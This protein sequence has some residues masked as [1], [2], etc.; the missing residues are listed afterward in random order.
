MKTPTPK[1][2]AAGKSPI[3][4][5]IAFIA[6]ET[7]VWI[8]IGS[9]KTYLS[10]KASF[11]V[12]ILSYIA[13]NFGNLIVAAATT[14]YVIFTYYLLES[15]ETSRRHSVE[16]LLKVRWY[17][18]ERPVERRLVKSGDLSESVGKWFGEIGVPI[19]LGA[20]PPSKQ[21]YVIVEFS[22]ARNVLIGEIQMGFQA[23]L[24]IPGGPSQMAMRDNI[25]LKD[26]NLAQTSNP[27]AVTVLD[28]GCIPKTASVNAS[29]D[30]LIYGSIEDIA[31]ERCVGEKSYVTTGF[32][33]LMTAPVPALTPTAT[34]EGQ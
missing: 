31:F 19:D 15:T 3:R 20:L 18:A 8:L 22:N 26:L 34:P 32:W 13:D 30:N 27:I 9:A 25:N 12:E 4:L 23:G 11:N 7:M 14:A 6:I 29:L 10:G 1:D 21:R 5:S 33:E 17:L 2:T 16:P 28:L 24:S